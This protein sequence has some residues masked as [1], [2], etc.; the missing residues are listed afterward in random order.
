MSAKRSALMPEVATMAEQGASDQEADVIVGLLVPA[1][2]S[3]EIVGLLHREI[4]KAIALPE[5]RER[6]AVLGF[7]PVGSTSE[8]FGN[9]IKA[10]LPKWAKVVR[11]AN[12]KIQ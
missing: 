7:D 11:E 1:G 3:K 8:E 5:V 2:T 10:E 9:W 12:L 6:L 4:V